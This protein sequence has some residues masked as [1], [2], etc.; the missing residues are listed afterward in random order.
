MATSDSYTR[1]PR[2]GWDKT[3]KV[4][5]AALL[6]VLGGLAI[7][8]FRIVFVPLAIGAIMA[9]VL[10]PA[11]SMLG[12]RLRLPHGLATGVVYLIGL[13]IVIPLVV[14]SVPWVI[15][16]VLFVRN[17]LIRFV[18]YLAATSSDTIEIVGFELS[19]GDL[20]SELTSAA[21]ELITSAASESLSLLFNAAE[22]LLLVIFT[23]L[24]AF[25]LT[26]DS[27]RFLNWLSGLIPLDYREDALQLLSEIDQVWSAFLRG[28]VI[29]AL[30][31]GTI[32][33]GVAAALGLPQPILLGLFG[34][35][36]EFLPSVGHA[37]WLITVSILALI[38]GS[39]TLP[40]SNVLFLAI[41]IGV[42]IAYTQFDLNFLIPRIIGGEVHLHPMVVIVGIIVGAQVGGVLGVAL[43]APM[44]AS[45][46]VIGRYIYAR[47]LDLEPFPMVGPPTI[48]PAERAQRAEE[49][50]ATR[51][52]RGRMR[53][54]LLR[55]RHQAREAL[56][57]Q[58]NRG[59][60]EI[61][62]D[63]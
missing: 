21:R 7:Y 30:I 37:I 24:I 10:T 34:G 57:R 14:L 41:V 43:A 47:M 39:T 27:E 16:R 23:F 18:A 19:V 32:L 9:Y 53:P 12:R 2:R 44:I 59:R 61:E 5:I 63:G 46:R 28:Q 26:R 17:E 62:N 45:L 36:M 22:T 20:T 55:L 54:A 33:T 3:T 15:D 4:M 1:P 49:M 31:A 40:V 56:R 11:V 52:R 42:H 51:Q 29:L 35:L 8:L 13:A 50:G 48:P 6:L 25:Y 58:R 38:D 60:Q